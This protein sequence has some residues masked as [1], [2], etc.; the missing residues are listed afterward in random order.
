MEEITN[1]Y[2]KEMIKELLGT[3]WPEKGD[4]ETGNEMRKRIGREIRE[5]KRPKPTYPSAESRAKLPNFDENGKYIYPEG[6]G[7]RYTEYLRDNPDS[8]EA[9][10]Y[11]NKVS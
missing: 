7:F 3:S 10:S 4:R 9:S 1:G 8:T 2:T 5:G 6:S 11:G